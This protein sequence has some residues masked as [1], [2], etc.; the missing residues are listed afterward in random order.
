M[1]DMNSISFKFIT[2]K[3]LAFHAHALTPISFKV[4][5]ILA[6]ESQVQQNPYIKISIEKLAE[7]SLLSIPSTIKSLKE[8]QRKNLIEKQAATSKKT[9]TNVYLLRVCEQISEFSHTSSMG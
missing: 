3:D 7:K 4:L 6:Y 9:M 8:L 1:I 2:L 5:F